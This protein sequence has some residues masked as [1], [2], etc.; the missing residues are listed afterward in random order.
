MKKAPFVLAILFISFLITPT[1]IRVFQNETNSIVVSSFFDEEQ[2]ES[3]SK[4]IFLYCDNTISFNYPVE[5]SEE[6]KKNYKDYFLSLQ[7]ILPCKYC[8]DNY[9]KNLEIIPITDEV[10]KNRLNL[11]KWV[12]DIHNLVN[13]NLNKPITLTYDQVR[14]RYEN[15]RARCLTKEEELNNLNKN[16]KIEKGCTEFLIGEKCKIT[17][18][19]VPQTENCETF[20]IDERCQVK[21]AVS[22]SEKIFQGDDLIYKNKYLSYKN[23]YLNLKNKI[24]SFN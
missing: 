12:Y 15:F 21:K 14:D 6:H 5:P 13:K 23:K 1:I 8:R 11:S 17:L 10:L 24:N 19:F 3:D 22:K 4:L 18:N 16:K 9:K 7:N 20:K 2:G